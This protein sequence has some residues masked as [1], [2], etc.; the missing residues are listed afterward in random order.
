MSLLLFVTFISLLCFSTY[1]RQ[2]TVPV[3]PLTDCAP[4]LSVLL[5]MARF[6]SF[7]W[8]SRI[9]L[10][11]HHTSFI[12]SALGGP[13]G[14]LP[15]LAV[16]D[17]AAHLGRCRPCCPPWPLQTVL[18]VLQKMPCER[19]EKLKVALASCRAG[20]TEMA[21]NHWFTSWVGR[22]V[23]NQNLEPWQLK[24][25]HTSCL[26][27]QPLP[28]SVLGWRC[29]PSRSSRLLPRPLVSSALDPDLQAVSG[30][31]DL[32]P[33][34]RLAR[35]P[36]RLQVTASKQGR[37]PSSVAAASLYVSLSQPLGRVSKLAPGCRCLCLSGPLM[38]SL[39]SSA[40]EP[41]SESPPPLGVPPPPPPAPGSAPA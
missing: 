31:S 8:P 5:Q 19:G 26:S 21:T 15:T 25:S 17:G 35:R 39:L 6:R 24:F 41:P 22:G 28:A 10:C 14:R 37:R 12:H 29:S 30:P 36:L 32:F 13:S 9:P 23:C 11:T 1:K 40:L 18:P 27:L 34:R 7:L 33:S 4:R 38:R 3:F 2:H 16:A 20:R